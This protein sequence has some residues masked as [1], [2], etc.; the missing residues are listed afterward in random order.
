[1]SHA[2]PF[3]IIFAALILWKVYDIGVEDGRKK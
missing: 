2:I 1:M 3:I